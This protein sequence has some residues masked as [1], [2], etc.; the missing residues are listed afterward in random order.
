M[1]RLGL[2]LLRRDTLLEVLVE[3]VRYEGNVGRHQYSQLEEDVE[4]DVECNQLVLDAV[5]ALQPL[6]IQAHVPVREVIEELEELR[7][8][9]V[10]S[11]MLHLVTHL[12]DEVLFSGDDPL[13]RYV[14]EEAL[15]Y[16]LI[17][18]ECL[19]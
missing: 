3:G 4:E 6:P 15:C 10:E 8:H 16:V 7:H 18:H 9:G 13:I 5:L 17:E 12:L 1:D 2:I 14:V 11:V 19:Q